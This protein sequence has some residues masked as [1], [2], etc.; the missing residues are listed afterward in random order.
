MH[1]SKS[2][3][4][5]NP[6][7][8][9]FSNWGCWNFSMFKT[10]TLLGWLGWAFVWYIQHN[11][12]CIF[13]WLTSAITFCR[14]IAYYNIIYM[15]LLWYIYAEPCYMVTQPPVNAPCHLG[16]HTTDK[17]MAMSGCLLG[18][19]LNLQNIRMIGHAGLSRAPCLTP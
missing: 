1:L 17:A 8:L 16:W 2:Y 7:V 15:S 19:L 14:S 11:N 12:Y 18:G 4:N 6:L 3:F 9:L 10:W 13:F 5:V